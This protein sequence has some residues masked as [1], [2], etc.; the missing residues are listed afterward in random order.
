MTVLGAPRVF[1]RSLRN[2]FGAARLPSF[3]RAGFESRR[4]LCK[5]AAVSP[6]HVQAQLFL[7]TAARTKILVAAARAAS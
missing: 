5:P 7:P 2:W 3:H 4:Q 6:K 1:H